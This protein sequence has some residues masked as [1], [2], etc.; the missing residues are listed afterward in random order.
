MLRRASVSVQLPHMVRVA[1]NVLEECREVIQ[2]VPVQAEILL[3]PRNV[4]VVL[5]RRYQHRGQRDG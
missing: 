5:R 4:G 3:H 2:L 1:C